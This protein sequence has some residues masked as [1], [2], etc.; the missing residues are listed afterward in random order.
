MKLLIKKQEFSNI[1]HLFISYQMI[2]MKMMMKLNLHL[3]NIYPMM[4][5]NPTEPIENYKYKFTN[6]KLTSA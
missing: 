3:D 6:I 2:S 4:Y 1:I 5:Q